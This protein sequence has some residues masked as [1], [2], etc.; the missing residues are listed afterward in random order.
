MNELPKWMQTLKQ[1]ND[2]LTQLLNNPNEKDKVWRQN[3]TTAAANIADFYNEWL[4]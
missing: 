1:Q 2:L 3:V 4:R